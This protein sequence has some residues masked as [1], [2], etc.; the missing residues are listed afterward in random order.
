[1][2]AVEMRQSCPGRYE[3]HSM[4]TF[5]SMNSD[6]PDA[7][8]EEVHRGHD[9]ES[10]LFARVR[11]WTDLFP[12][13]RLG[14]TLRVAG[15]PPHV[16][17]VAVIFSVWWLGQ[18]LLVG[19][20]PAGNR[21]LLSRLDLRSVSDLPER[22]AA[23]VARHVHGSSPTSLLDVAAHLPWWRSLAGIAWSLLVWAPTAMLLARQGALLTAGR[24]MV[25]LKPG[26]NHVI[27]RA[28]AAWLAAAVPLACA[29]AIGLLIV[30]VG[31]LARF[32]EGI[33]V[34]EVLLAIVAAVIAI[35]CGVLVFGANAAVP[36]SWAALANERDPDALDSL[37]RGYEYLFRR[38]LQLL[39]YVAVSLGI[40]MAVGVLAAGVGSAAVSVATAMLAFSGGSPSVLL[41]TQ[42]VLQ[43]FPTVVVLTLA[44]SLLGSLY[45]LL[46]YDAGGQEV[47]DLWQPSPPDLPPLPDLP[48]HE[49]GPQKGAAGD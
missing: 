15:S 33:I 12:W 6:D 14:R 44:W 5:V 42:Q 43:Y 3:P 27:R 46:R 10:G 22:S 8:R 41:R 18:S 34:L 1:M 32:A 31:W 28:P 23:I 9:L 45:L 48:Q 40:V 37:S 30:I 20:D 19:D 13:L 24:T 29:I 35:A 47:E 21:I 7:G 39:W 25:G 26:M 2:A 36:L 11:E 4:A 49:S 16:F 17:L 38:P